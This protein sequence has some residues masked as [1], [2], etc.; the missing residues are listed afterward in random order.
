MIPTSDLVKL[1]GPRGADEEGGV[2][3][4]RVSLL[5]PRTH[6]KPHHFHSL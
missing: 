2:N 1:A 3:F 5:I 6:L 4:F